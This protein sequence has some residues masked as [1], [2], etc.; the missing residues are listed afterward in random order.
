MTNC[1]VVV[2]RELVAQGGDIRV[3][4]GGVFSLVSPLTVTKDTVLE[5]DRERVSIDGQNLTRHFIVTNG[6]KLHLA[7]L[8]MVNGRD[9]GTNGQN[10]QDGASPWAAQSCVPRRTWSWLTAP[11]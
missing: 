6:A 4:C 11:S 3:A 5:A 9:R 2:L 8:T 1:S 10:D 7:H